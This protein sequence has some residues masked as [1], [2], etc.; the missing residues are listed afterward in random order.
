M[1]NQIDEE[2]PLDPVMERV[3]VKMIRLLVVSI[4]IML[5]GLITVLGAVVYKISQSSEEAEV[6]ADTTSL[7]VVNTAPLLENLE[8]DL[9]DGARVIS[10]NLSN[11]NLLLD[12]R[13]ENGDRQFWVVDL[14]TGK[15]ISKVTTK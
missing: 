6:E 4:G 9:P 14:Q 10:S 12:L 3:R 2:E 15:I 5:L 11:Q 7:P 1:A 13:M 8:V